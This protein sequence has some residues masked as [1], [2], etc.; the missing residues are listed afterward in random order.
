MVTAQQQQYQRAF[1]FTFHHDGFHGFLNRDIQQV[2]QGLN[3]FGVRR[4]DFAQG[5]SRRSTFTL[6]AQSRRQFNVGSVIRAC[7]VGNHVFAAAGQHLK[8]MRACATDA[9]CVCRHRAVIQTQTVKHIA[10]R[11]VHHIV[12][13]F[14]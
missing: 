11:L 13:G 14:Q 5:F 6:L 8:L 10:I 12:S 7:A 4:V 2:H 3:G 1:F 9:A